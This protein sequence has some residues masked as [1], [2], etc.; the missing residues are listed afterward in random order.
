MVPN[1]TRDPSLS[2]YPG[3]GAAFSRTVESLTETRALAPEVRFQTADL[4]RGNALSAAAAFAA[5]R[6]PTFPY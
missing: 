4:F 1:G 6:N 3:K 5:K 2:Y